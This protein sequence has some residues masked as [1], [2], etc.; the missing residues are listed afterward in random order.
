MIDDEGE[1]MELGQWT[2]K[3]TKQYENLFQDLQG[4]VDQLIARIRR[5]EIR[6]ADEDHNYEQQSFTRA[7]QLLTLQ[8]DQLLSKNK[9]LESKNKDLENEKKTMKEEIEKL[10]NEK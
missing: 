4:Q 5:F 2:E 1:E 9:D 7:Y 8:V 10:K 6:W 3:W